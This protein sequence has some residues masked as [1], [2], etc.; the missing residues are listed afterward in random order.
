MVMVSS[1]TDCTTVHTRDTNSSDRDNHAYNGDFTYLY[2]FLCIYA[3]V[4]DWF[5]QHKSVAPHFRPYVPG[6]LPTT[7][8]KYFER[9]CRQDTMWSMWLT[10][11]IHVEQL[12][13]I[14]SN[15]GVYTGGRDSCLCINRRQSGLHY[16]R[17][18]PGTLG[19]LMTVWKDEYIAFPKNTVR[20]HWDGSPMGDRLY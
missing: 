18:R 15:I 7:W 11:Y 10:Y 17:A 5:H 20:L 19:R 13:G 3:C 6:A 16:Q 14:Y 12:Y 8:Y 9:F 4:Q 2:I 1:T